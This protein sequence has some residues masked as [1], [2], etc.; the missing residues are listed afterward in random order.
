[1]LTDYTDCTDLSHIDPAPITGYCLPFAAHCAN[2]A[3]SSLTM[4][5]K[6]D[7]RVIL[8]ISW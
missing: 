2:A 7:S 1:M 3:A 5:M 4:P 6:S 8:K